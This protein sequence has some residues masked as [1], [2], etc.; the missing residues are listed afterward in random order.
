M[1]AKS[2]SKPTVEEYLAFDVLELPAI[3]SRLAL[4]DVYSRVPGL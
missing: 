4:A 1:L 2:D 3:G